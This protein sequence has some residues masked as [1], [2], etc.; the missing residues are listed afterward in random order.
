[1]LRALGILFVMLV[2]A[3]AFALASDAGLPES[4]PAL[5]AAPSATPGSAAPAAAATAA[6]TM[7]PLPLPGGDGWFESLVAEL[8]S[9]YRE[10]RWSDFSG[11]LLTLTLAAFFSMRRVWPRLRVYATWAKF[12]RRQKAWAIFAV[13]LGLSALTNLVLA[14]AGFET[15]VIN[16]W[17]AGASAVASWKLGLELILDPPTKAEEAHS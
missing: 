7:Q 9:A 17:R 8:V 11:V 1:M 2:P 14:H 15:V 6:P 5:T 10:E 3:E 4:M 16:A 13:A 12:S